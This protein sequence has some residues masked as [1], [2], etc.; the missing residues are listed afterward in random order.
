MNQRVFVS[1]TYVDLIEHREAVDS[2]AIRQ[3]GDTDVSMENFGAR[4]ERPKAECFR[5]IREASNLNPVGIYAHRYGY[6]PDGEQKSITES[7]Y[8]AAGNQ[9]LPRFI[10]LVD[11][12][13]E[14]CAWKPMLID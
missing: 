4:D 9:N 7:E 12:Y 13:L 11:S 10:Y 6:V 8:D 1:S 14:N 3:L 5:L 2:R